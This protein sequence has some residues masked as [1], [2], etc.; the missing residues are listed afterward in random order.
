MGEMY[1]ERLLDHYR[2]P[3]NKGHFDAPDPSTSSTQ[4]LAAEEYNPLCGD[5]V[6]IE[7][8][9]EADQLV[10][11]RWDGRGCALCLGAA[12]ILTEVAQGRPL[13]EL[14]GLGEDAFLAELQSPIR[15]ARLKCALLPWMALRH[16]LFGEDEW[17]NLER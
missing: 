11:V 1:T 2:H 6:T 14:A 5:R 12:S 3:R 16:A 10:Q 4:L 15:P 17:P 9:V 13:A 7:A 8:C